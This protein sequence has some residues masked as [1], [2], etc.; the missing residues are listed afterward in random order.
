MSP[1]A[2]ILGHFELG[3]G[4]ERGPSLGMGLTYAPLVLTKF[5]I[6]VDS[7]SPFAAPTR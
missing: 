6:A 3:P 1:A 4:P 2:I 5:A 7:V